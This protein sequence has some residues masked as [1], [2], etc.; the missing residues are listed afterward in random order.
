[1]CMEGLVCHMELGCVRRVD[2]REKRK[3]EIEKG[4]GRSIGG[5]NERPRESFVRDRCGEVRRNSRS[6]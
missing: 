4:E 2:G 1:M 6:R 5:W 3:Q